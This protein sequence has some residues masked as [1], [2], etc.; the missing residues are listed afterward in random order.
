MCITILFFCFYFRAPKT[1]S[2]LA[3][4][5]PS[6]SSSTRRFAPDMES[7]KTSGILREE[8][9]GAPEEDP[10]EGPSGLLGHFMAAPADMAKTSEAPCNPSLT[11]CQRDSLSNSSTHLKSSP[12]LGKK[13]VFFKC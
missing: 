9:F 2:D 11:R 3:K 12:P 4:T 6:S 5:S 10:W 8:S 13:C 1:D 7:A